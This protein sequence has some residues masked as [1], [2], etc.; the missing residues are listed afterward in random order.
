MCRPCVAPPLPSGRAGARAILA[1][2]GSIYA[3]GGVLLNPDGSL[4]QYVATNEEGSFV[5]PCPGG[6]KANF[7]W[8]YSANGSA[9]G[10]ERHRHP[11]LPRQL[12]HGTAGDGR[13][14]A[15]RARRHAQGRV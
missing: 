6:T 10:V 14:P 15:G 11:G 1:A 2:N 9:G 3:I 4:N 13:P 12:Q 7:R 8:H 5:A